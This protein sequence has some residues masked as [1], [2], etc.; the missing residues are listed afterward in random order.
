MYTYFLCA[1][2]A[3]RELFDVKIPGL[4]YLTVKIEPGTSCLFPLYISLCILYFSDLTESYF[5]G[6]KI[7]PGTVCQHELAS[8]S[9]E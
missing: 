4:M 5:E 9:G 1:V 2:T 3:E 6:I 8:G 7:E